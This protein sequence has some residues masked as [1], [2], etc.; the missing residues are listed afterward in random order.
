MREQGTDPDAL[1]IIVVLSELV[2]TGSQGQ[3]ALAGSHSSYSLTT[4][5]MIR[6][7]LTEF[8]NQFR[9]VIPKIEVTGSP[10]HKKI[11]DPFCLC[12]V[13]DAPIQ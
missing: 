4:P 3:V 12:R 6:Q 2:L 7:I 5:N 8:L 11:N 1:V 9:L 13:M 10:A